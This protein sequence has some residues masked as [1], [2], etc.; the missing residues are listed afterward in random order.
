MTI[1]TTLRRFSFDV[2]T[3]EGK[4]AWQAFQAE[5]RSGPKC[6]GP[7]LFDVWD[8]V[9][10]LDGQEIALD[11]D[12]LFSNQWNTSE[13]VRVFDYALQA[14]S[15]SPN[16]SFKLSSPTHIRRGHYLEQTE[17]MRALRAETHVCGFRGHKARGEE[18]TPF[19]GKCIGSEYLQEGEIYL[20]RMMPLD[21]G[22]KR[23]QPLTE[24]E[25]AERLPLYLEAQST[26][27]RAKVEKFRASVSKKAQDL[28]DRAVEERNGF[29]WLI[30]NGLGNMA[31][32]NVIYYPHKE[33]FSFGWRKPL[34]EAETAKVLAVISEFRHGYDIKTAD[35]RT[36]SGN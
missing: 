15:N 9:A 26:G 16:L 7:I 2:S 4:K 13:G 36:L 27:D 10:D 22:D 18:V 1:K 14:A 11:T 17:E 29:L 25:K 28:I 21:Q 12:S 30:D 5:R 6:C 3:P 23:R 20:T 33:R 35:G 19:C 32:Q 24:D 31:S 34:S 8:M